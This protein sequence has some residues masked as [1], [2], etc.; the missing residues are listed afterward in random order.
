MN[1]LNRI[2]KKREDELPPWVQARENG[3]LYID[4][5][6]ERYQRYFKDEIEYNSQWIE[7]GK[8]IV[9]TNPKMKKPNWRDYI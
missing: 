7:D 2:F 4:I 1:W 5:S 6:D 8:I 9:N 3:S